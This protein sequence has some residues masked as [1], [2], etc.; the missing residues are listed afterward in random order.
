MN[1][2]P[3]LMIDGDRLTDGLRWF[4]AAASVRLRR[5]SAA[6]TQE[7]LHGIRGWLLAVLRFAITR[8]QADRAAVV[9]LAR[10][11]DRLRS[12]GGQSGF[13]FF[14]RTSI[15]LCNDIGN[16][17]PAG[18]ARLYRHVRNVDDDRLRAAFE[19]VLNLKC[20]ARPAK[21]AAR[22]RAYLWQGL[23]PS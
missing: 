6:V 4:V 18:S 10:Q 20:T 23:R 1:F 22:E 5:M 2:D 21:P 3:A 8:E 15:E 19:A 13:T 16:R 14:V 11:M 9:A 12:Y 17:T 7:E